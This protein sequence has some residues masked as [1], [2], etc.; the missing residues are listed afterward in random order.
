[1]VSHYN[2]YSAH[3]GSASALVLAHF[4]VSQAYQKPCLLSDAHSVQQEGHKA[5]NADNQEREAE[6]LLSH[7]TH[8]STVDEFKNHQQAVKFFLNSS[9]TSRCL[10]RNYRQEALDTSRCELQSSPMVQAEMQAAGRRMMPGES[11]LAI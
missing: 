10:Q 3:P 7:E 9:A 6:G 8:S 4:V 5:I 11:V 2:N 1:M